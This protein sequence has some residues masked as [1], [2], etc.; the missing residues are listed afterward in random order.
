MLYEMWSN[1]SDQKHIDPLGDHV[2]SGLRDRVKGGHRET[3]LSKL[4]EQ[5]S[6]LR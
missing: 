5:W 2:K 3:E 6:L 4:G 1:K